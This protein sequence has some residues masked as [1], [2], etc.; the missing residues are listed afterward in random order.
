MRSAVD[1]LVADGTLAPAA[2]A[3]LW[4]YLQRAALSMVNTFTDQPPT[5]PTA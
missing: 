5:Q 2:E 1:A 4:D 3:V